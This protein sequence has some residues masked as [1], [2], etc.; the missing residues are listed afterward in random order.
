MNT[1]FQYGRTI[2]LIFLTS[3]VIS[4]VIGNCI[5]E[6]SCHCCYS[7]RHGSG[8]GPMRDAGKFSPVQILLTSKQHSHAAMARS[9]MWVIFPC[10]FITEAKGGRATVPLAL[11]KTRCLLCSR[12]TARCLCGRST[13]PVQQ[14]QSACATEYS[15]CEANTLPVQQK[16]HS[17]SAKTVPVQQKHSACATETML[18]QQNTVPLQ[19]KQ[20]LCKQ[21]RCLCESDRVFPSVRDHKALK[22]PSLHSSS[23]NAVPVQQKHGACAAECSAC[24]TNTVP[25]QQQRGACAAETRCLCSRNTVPAVQ[26][27]HGA[28]AANTVCHEFESWAQK[29]HDDAQGPPNTAM[30]GRPPPPPPSPLPTPPPHPPTQRG[31]SPFLPHLAITL[32]RCLPPSMGLRVHFV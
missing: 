29:G 3:S 11:D 32:P 22:G 13:V 16:H 4:S 19:Q 14:K 12:S 30:E 20:C 1:R 2:S 26:Q 31:P 27:K 18:V 24:A 15:A 25:V 17:S 5:R 23:A 7:R 8:T 21:T 10:G 6:V 28:R 9:E